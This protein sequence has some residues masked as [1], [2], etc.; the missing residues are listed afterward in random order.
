MVSYPGSCNEH[1][2]SLMNTFSHSFYRLVFIAKDRRGE[3]TGPVKN[4]VGD[5]IVQFCLGKASI[6][7]A[8]SFCFS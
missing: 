6:V 7:S 3:K 4:G 8:S 1:Y 2:K 5:M